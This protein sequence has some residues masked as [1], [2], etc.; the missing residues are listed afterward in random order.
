[1]NDSLVRYYP[2]ATHYLHIHVNMSKLTLSQQQLRLGSQVSFGQFVRFC[3]KQH[4]QVVHDVR[5]AARPPVNIVLIIVP[6]P[7][8]GPSVILHSPGCT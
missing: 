3:T 5:A 4:T 1:M 8:S 6:A 7:D 2:F